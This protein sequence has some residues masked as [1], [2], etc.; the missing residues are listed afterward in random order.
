MSLLG[1]ELEKI[2]TSRLFMFISVALILSNGILFWNYESKK[3]SYFY[4]Y[5][6]K[7]DYL[8]YQTEGSS[9]D[10]TSFYEEE[11]GRKDEYLKDYAIFIKEMGKRANEMSKLDIFSEPNGFSN[12]NLKKTIKDY[13]K[14]A[15]VTPQKTDTYAIDS[16]ASYEWGI[17]SQSVFTI[18]VV[19]FLI[20]LER[21]NGLFLLLRGCKNGNCGVAVSKYL[22]AFIL[23]GGYAVLQSLSEIVVSLYIYGE[24]PIHSVAQ[25][26]SLFR[27][28]TFPISFCEVIVLS[29]I[30]RVGI[31]IV[32]ASLMCTIGFAVYKEFNGLISVLILFVFLLLLGSCIPLSGKYSMFKCISPFFVWTVKNAIGEYHNLNIFGFPISKGIIQI[33]TGIIVV[34]ITTCIGCV[35]FSKGSQMKQG[36]LAEK[37]LI[38]FR[39]K[40]DVLFRHTSLLYYELY[41]ILFQKKKIIIMLFM[42]LWCV[43]EVGKASKTNYY[44]T[45][46]E[47]AYHF[48]MDKYEGPL[49]EKTQNAILS[50]MS[51]LQDEKEE[52]MGALESD[53]NVDITFTETRLMENKIYIDG[54]N[55]VLKQLEAIKG[56]NDNAGLNYL[57]DEPAYE[58]YFNRKRDRIIE[59]IIC[60]LCET[61]IVS[62][63]YIGDTTMMPV[64]RTTKRGE[65][66]IWNSKK[67]STLLVCFV[68]FIIYKIPDSIRFFKI[69]KLQCFDAPMSSF[70]SQEYIHAVKLGQVCVCVYILS[71]VIFIA[72]GIVELTLSKYV[73]NEI[74]TWGIIGIPII[75]VGVFFYYFSFDSFTMI[76]R[77]I[78]NK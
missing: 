66:S 3:E 59:W 32:I 68:S 35:F 51:F 37:W 36:T 27:G 54:I 18:M 50:E 71:A 4:V 38:M 43:I 56:Q 1:F 40:W 13:N 26:S 49:S 23:V 70:V 29:L 28:C 41:K 67:N 14:V 72:V 6:H 53:K 22:S 77:L 12:K 64:L 63:I 25:A 16:Y 73:K 10:N 39:S 46:E 7:E 31:A 78:T 5:E 62:G 52:I 44:L 74:V 47:A 42:I 48:Y 57:V 61:F 15:E 9:A 76:L 2:I 30:I 55:R 19:W 20:Y 34:V 60:I 75:A 11:S 58:H 65:K 21:D 17:I 8:K 33:I 24:I 45:L 69:D